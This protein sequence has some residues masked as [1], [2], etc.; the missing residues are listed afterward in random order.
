MMDALQPDPTVSLDRLLGGI[1][2][3]VARILDRALSRT[4]ITVEEAETLL[5]TSGRE[6]AVLMATADQLRR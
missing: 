1:A 2:P 4:E 3:T 6:L 5:G